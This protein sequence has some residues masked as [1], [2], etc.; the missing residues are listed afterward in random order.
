MLGIA[1]MKMER[2]V[3]LNEF[4]KPFSSEDEV[5]IK[6]KISGICGSDLNLFNLEEQMPGRPLSLP[7]I[8]G[9]EFCGVAESVGPRVQTI[10]VGDRVAGETHI[11]CMSCFTCQTG[12]AH[13]CPNQRNVGR[14]VNGSFAEYI[15]IPE[16]S[17]RKVPDVLTDDEVAMLEPLGVAVHAVREND[18]TGDN[19]VVLGCGPLGLMTIATARAFGASLVFATSHSPDKLQKGLKMGADQVFQADGEGTNKKILSEA[20]AR[21]IGTVIDMSG[22]D[23]AIHQGLDLLRPGGTMVLAGIP[24]KDFHFN[25]LLY[26]IFKEIKLVGIFGRKMWETWY[27][28]EMLFEQG[29]V[30]TELLIGPTYS[31]EDHEKAFN[32]AFSGKF[33]RIFIAPSS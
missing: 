26:S 17:V 33:G 27:L 25:V 30:S 3:T 16:V 29:K 13:I 2:G 31:I 7:F 15:V 28:S 12:D 19:V 1:K 10:Q 22:S 14:T 21:G 18:V 20:G 23:E 4:P 8:L 5:L 11:P 32:D 6:V 9:H 24:K